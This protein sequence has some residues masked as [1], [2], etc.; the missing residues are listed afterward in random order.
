MTGLAIHLGKDA[1]CRAQEAKLTL[2]AGSTR[3]G[4]PTANNPQATPH[5]PN[6][7]IPHA[8]TVNHHGVESVGPME[9]ASVLE[10]TDAI[11]G[12]DAMEDIDTMEDV[13]KM[14]GANVMEDVD[15]MEDVEGPG[16]DDDESGGFHNIFNEVLDDIIGRSEV[17]AQLDQQDSP[18]Q[19]FLDDGPPD[20]LIPA[21]QPGEFLELYPDPRAGA[22]IRPATEEEMR[23]KEPGDI[24]AL[25]DPEN[26]EVADFMFSTGLSAREREK[27]MNLKKVSNYTRKWPLMTYR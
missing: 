18:M 24:G 21:T 5:N 16:I 1:S 14:E 22:P 26:F 11:G 13:D 8:D 12:V 10:Y 27:F 9:G 20:G 6:D 19:D 7:E 23:Q 17:S 2:R 25:A 15:A 3:S 4:P